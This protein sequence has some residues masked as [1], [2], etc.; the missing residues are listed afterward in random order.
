MCGLVG[1]VDRST[2][3]EKEEYINNMKN[4]IIHRGPD[5][6]GTYVDDDIALGFRRLSIIDLD[7]GSQ[8]IYNEAGNMLIFFNGEIY[9]YQEIKR[10]LIAKGHTFKTNTDTEVILHGYEEYGTRILNKLRG[11]FAFVIW[12]KDSKELFGARDHYGIKPFYYT[13]M[14]GNFMFGSEIKS[15]EGHPSFQKNLNKDAL[16]PYLTFQYSVLRETF[17][18]GVYKLEP[19]HYFTYK[20]KILDIKPYYEVSFTDNG[21]VYEQVVE[22]IEGVVRES[23]EKH[24]ISDVKVGSFLSGGVDSS[25]ITKCLMPNKTFSVGFGNTGDEATFNETTYAKELSH[26]L[27]IENYSKLITPDEFFNA[28]EDVQYH[29]DEPHANLSAVPLYFLS[30]LTREHVTVVLSGEGADELFG[31]YESYGLCKEDVQ[32]RKMVPEGIRRFLGNVAKNM[33]PFHGRHFL[34][35]N[36]LP[37]E[38]YYIGQAMV[39]ED[40]EARDILTKEYRHGKNFKEITKPYFDKVKDQDDV[41]KMQYLDMHL[42]LPQ[43]ILLKADKM[44]MAHSIELRV[45]FLD[46]EVFKFASGLRKD[47]KIRNNTTKAALRDSANSILPEAWAKRKKKGFPVPFSKWI[48]EDKYYNIVKSTFEEEYAKEFF[49]IDTAL[50]MLDEHKAGKKNHGRKIWTMYAFLLWYKVYF[51]NS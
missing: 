9:N 10:E 37:V 21:K 30:Q 46:K 34:M 13:E 8:P 49:N 50:R 39:F 44:T 15:F 20:N 2:R 4:K 51:I 45:P 1:F 35:H 22:E 33:K 26:M 12:D 6:E 48:K 23:V 17:F 40:N 16:K 43:D 19:G 3:R 24:R 42:W 11:M 25:Y 28:L 32:Y 36:G 31:G 47:Y 41:V 18:K 38:D 5:S 27:G 14:G 29:S 7:G